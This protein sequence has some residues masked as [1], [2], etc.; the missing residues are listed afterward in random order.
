M[1]RALVL[2]G[3][4]ACV[5]DA[6]AASGCAAAEV[7]L[8]RHAE[9][10]TSAADDPDVVLSDAGA[11]RATALAAWF[12]GR[13]VDAIYATHLRRTQHTAAPLAAAHDLEI[14]VLPADGSEGLVARLHERH[15][16]EHVVVVGHSNT[17]PEIAA[18]LGAEA[19]VIGE[20]DFGTIYVLTP[21]H[22]GLRPESFGEPAK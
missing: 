3:L 15:C 12:T 11:R 13:E 22:P 9:K 14:R 6:L 1:I 16:G 17:V 20:K 7:Y 10:A 8:V 18:A 5:P 4:A 2:V 19:P 21:G